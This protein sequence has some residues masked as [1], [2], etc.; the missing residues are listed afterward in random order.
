[1]IPLSLAEVADAVGG[2]LGDGG[3]VTISA[4]STDSRTLAPGA[5]FVALPGQRADGHDYVDQAVVAG[6]AAVVV[7]RPV[8]AEVPAITVD[9]TWEA[10]AALGA[11]V[12]ERVDPTVVAVTGSVGKTTTKDLTAAALR[13]G[14]RTVAAEG[15][16]NNE[17]GVPL[18]LLALEPDTEVLVV[19]LG[20]RGIGDLAQLT[21]W[22]RPDVGIV[23]RVAGVHLEQFGDLATVARAKAELVTALPEAGWA[24]LN[25]D[26]PRVAAMASETPARVL[27]YGTDRDCDVWA[28]RV[29]LDRLA[30]PTVTVASPWG[31]AE[32]RLPVAGA[33]NVPNALA[34]I[35]TA[36]V[37]GVPP[38][39]AAGAIADTDVSAWRGEVR[40]VGGAVV[41]NDAYNANP[42][43]VRAALRTL[44][45]VE[46]SGRAWAVLGI[47]AEIGPD[48]DAE[49]RGV[50]VA[51]A[52]LGVDRLVVVGGDAAPIAAGARDA[53]LAPA[54]VAAVDDAEAALAIL[55]GELEPGDA[56]LVKAS[57]VAGLEQVADGLADRLGAGAR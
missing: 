46:R 7:S 21:P 19:E 3:M 53:G 24:V 35:A 50:G 4:V 41:L 2:R 40:E 31:S 22:V 34:A 52:E 27:R 10:L 32:V 30:V 25:A 18:T 26:D 12:R 37:L 47:M 17:L 11:A 44:A 38:H 9:D 49:H 6:A 42:T 51:A 23:T 8:G 54:R 13:A 28:R 39:A 1:M 36:G 5:L 15:S 14:R 33:H 43:S 48:H 16:F 45:A 55:V 56:V 29:R 57:R 20:S